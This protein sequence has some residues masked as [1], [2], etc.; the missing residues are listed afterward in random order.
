MG[1]NASQE[2]TKHGPNSCETH[3]YDF[4]PWF[5]FKTIP[6]ICG[7]YLSDVHHVSQEDGKKV[8]K[9]LKKHNSHL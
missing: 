1:K 9:H 7:T 4:L 5:F 6:I 2:N 3:P 8:N